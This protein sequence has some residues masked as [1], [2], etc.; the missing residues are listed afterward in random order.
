[1]A[2][3]KP[4]EGPAAIKG[5][6]L[7]ETDLRTVER[8][9]AGM[10]VPTATEHRLIEVSRR[11]AKIRR[12]VEIHPDSL[13]CA[14]LVIELDEFPAFEDR[15]RLARIAADRPIP[16]VVLPHNAPVYIAAFSPDGTRV[17][18]ASEDN[19]ARVW[20]VNWDLILALLRESTKACLTPS[21]RRELIGESTE[22]SQAKYEEC[23][24][25]YGR[26]PLPI[27]SIT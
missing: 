19:T 3:S 23:E 7:N 16:M 27:L 9:R 25:Q 10:R 26:K 2:A 13:M 11:M 17:L 8:G 1:M 18:T 22:E 12:T 20:M 15:T 6:I 24:R 14:L 21:Q 5:M 4:I